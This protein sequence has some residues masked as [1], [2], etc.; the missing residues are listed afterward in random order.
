MIVRRDMSWD[1]VAERVES[2]SGIAWDGCHKIYVLMDAEQVALMREYGYDLLTTS[3]ESSP[4][5]MMRLLH[6]WYDESCGLK[7]ISAVTTNHD[8]P[9]AGFEDLIAQFEGDEEGEEW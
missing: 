7:F 6:E 4:E 1:L 8:D 9:N 3:D 5:E 2:A